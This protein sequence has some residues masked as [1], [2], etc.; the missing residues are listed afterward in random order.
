M[1]DPKPLVAKLNAIEKLDAKELGGLYDFA[2][3]NRGKFE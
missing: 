2:I 3:V 1:D